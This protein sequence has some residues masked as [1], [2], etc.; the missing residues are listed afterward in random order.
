MSSYDPP[1]T[2]SPAKPQ[3]LPNFGAH[4]HALYTAL[5][6]GSPFDSTARLMLE[7]RVPAIPTWREAQW[8]H[9]VRMLQVLGGVVIESNE[10]HD[11]LVARIA[12][13]WVNK[14]AEHRDALK[15]PKPKPEPV[16]GF[17]STSRVLR[18]GDEILAV[19]DVSI[20]IKRTIYLSVP[21]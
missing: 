10:T 11:K 9:L 5:G 21:R 12:R 3:L 19:R 8:A 16:E 20:D 1:W 18:T 17:H 2:V 7:S 4:E 6:T 13:M 15:A 14:L